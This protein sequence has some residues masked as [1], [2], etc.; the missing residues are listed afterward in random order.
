[1]PALDRGSARGGWSETVSFGAGGQWQAGPADADG[2]F[3]VRQGEQPVGTV[4]WT[5]GGEHNRLNALAAL[6]AA[7]HAGVAAAEGVAALSRFGGVQRRMELR[8][9]AGGVKRSEERRVGKEC[10][11]TCRS[12]WST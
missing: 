6:A 9:T 3:D 11:G 8:G 7:Q 1:M 5:L 2:A 4:R 12:R 10:V